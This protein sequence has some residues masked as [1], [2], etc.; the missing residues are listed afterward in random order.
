MIYQTVDFLKSQLNNYIG[1]KLGNGANGNEEKVNYPKL[2]KV[3]P[4]NFPNNSITP[5][6]INIEEEKTLRASDRY[7]STTPD[8]INY[9]VNP[10]I[11]IDIFLLFIAK[12][13]AYEESLKY[14][15]YIIKFFQSNRY[16]NHQNSP[17]LSDEIEYLMVELQTMPFRE[18]NEVWNALRTT[19][20]PSVLYKVKMLVYK[21]EEAEMATRIV[22]SENTITKL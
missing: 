9:H 3:D 19:Y 5:I 4:I 22:E 1:F 12:F 21:D 7:L 6:L 17:D 11:K 2:D 15:S 20:L 18:L 8:G 14:L 13:T 16:F 10:E